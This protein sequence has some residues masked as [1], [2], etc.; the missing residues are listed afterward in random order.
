[1][2]GPKE[3]TAI[4]LERIEA[5]ICELAGHLA[6]AEC[7]FLVLVGDFDAREG[8]ASWDMPS[9]AAWLAWRCQIAPT[10]CPSMSGSG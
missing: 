4:P 7:R 1:M 8:W 10:S 6:A 5:Q 3:T 9:C 2:T